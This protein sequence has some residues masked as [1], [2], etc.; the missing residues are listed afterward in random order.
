MDYRL[1]VNVVWYTLDKARKW[2]IPNLHVET[3]IPM[4]WFPIDVIKDILN[5]YK[6]NIGAW[7]AVNAVNVLGFLKPF[8]AVCLLSLD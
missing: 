5:C 3:Q 7:M 1:I 4:K 6:D 8:N 2:R